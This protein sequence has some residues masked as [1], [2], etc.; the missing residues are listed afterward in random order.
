M[1]LLF[2]R[3]DEFTL[4]YPV[5]APP[6]FKFQ[7]QLS[8]IDGQILESYYLPDEKGIPRNAESGKKDVRLLKEVSRQQEKRRRER[9]SK[10]PSYANR[11]ISTCQKSLFLSRLFLQFDSA[12]D[13]WWQRYTPVYDSNLRNE[14]TA[15][16][17]F[18]ACR[19]HAS[20]VLLHRAFISGH[21][22]TAQLSPNSLDILNKS[23]HEM[24]EMIRFIV[25][26]G[27]AIKCGLPLIAHTFNC[28]MIL[29]REAWKKRL[30]NSEHSFE[31]PK[32]CLD[33]LHSQE[34]R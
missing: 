9:C 5:G 29:L 11:I 32:F 21:R 3:D 12:L 13:S 34:R 26:R 17:L 22:A 7:I 25:D 10:G 15:A 23:A 24:V 1:L 28:G 31:E 6:A 2:D 14:G 20:R 16:Y 27:Q 18:L 30:R 8:Q 4:D 33:F 19:A